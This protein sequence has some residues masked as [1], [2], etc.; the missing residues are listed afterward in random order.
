MRADD[1]TR[2][3]AVV[4][5]GL[6]GHGIAQVLARQPG[7]V[8]LYD[9]SA[10]ALERAVERIATSLDML[11]RH[12]LVTEETVREQRERVRTTTDLERAVDGAR[13]VVEAAPENLDLKRQ[14]FVKLER[15]APDD[16]ILATNS[17]GL[18]I[19][20]ITAGIDG[21][22]RAVG[23]HF[24]LPAQIVPLVEVSRGP[25]TSDGVMERT[26]DHW[27]A[28]GKEPIRVEKDIPG[29]VAN[30]M[31]AA[32]VREA[33]S[34]LGE[35]VA[36][37]EDIDKAVRRSFGLRFLVSGPLEQRDLGGLD[38]HVALAA[39]LWPCL[40]CSS[41]AHPFVVDKVKRGELGVRAG[42]GFHDW[43][44]Q[45]AERVRDQKNEALVAHMARL[46]LWPQSG[47]A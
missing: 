21:G 38:L 47:D 42:R 15:L 5:A 9:V 4:G 30:R 43:G 26:L 18:S 27:K 10:A 3:R 36:S 31:Q 13:F 33:T 32:L 37:A 34:L 45:D 2:A 1:S 17:S 24:F 20:A 44:E 11:A 29:Y 25:T 12:G 41:E 16:A 28:C 7:T 40:N 14:L 46:G 19:A 22:W 8:W 39:E 23:S 35:G 6:M